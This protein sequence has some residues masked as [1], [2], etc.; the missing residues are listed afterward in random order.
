MNEDHRDA[1]KLYATR[2]AGKAD[3]PWRM[4]GC[5]PDGIDLALGTDMARL[6]FG[7]RVETP[8]AARLE[9]VRMSKA[10]RQASTDG[11]VDQP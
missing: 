10:A 8:D 5:D 3:G 7:N 2:L 4:V 9:L 6:A 11:A 1:V